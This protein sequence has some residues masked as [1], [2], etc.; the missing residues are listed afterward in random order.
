MHSLSKIVFILT[1]VLLSACTSN[2][3]APTTAPTN[4]PAAPISGVPYKGIMQ[5][6]G[7]NGVITLGSPAATVTLD[8][9]SDYLCPTCRQYATE[10]EPAVLEKYVQTGKIR[11]ALY[12]VLNFGE[13]S[14]RTS[15]ASACAARQ[16]QGWQM[17]ELLFEKQPEVWG[18]SD[19]KVPALMKTFAATLSGLDQARFAACI[20]TREMQAIIEKA[21]TEQRGRGI[22]IQP[23]FEVNGKR[24]NGA[25][26]I[27]IFSQ[28]LDEA[29]AAQGTRPQ[30]TATP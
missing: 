27:D 18:T 16:G 5:T 14:L 9:Y 7:V 29:L 28:Y 15:E 30:P 2:P 12:Y 13:R 6:T 20:D 26:P 8:D 22:T 24:F 21:D 10:T 3:A 17:H 23:I 19:D 11:I 4:P 1:L 25:Q